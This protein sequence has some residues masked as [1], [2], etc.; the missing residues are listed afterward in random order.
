MF[1]LGKGCG[2]CILLWT[3]TAGELS[4]HVAGLLPLRTTGMSNPHPFASSL[5]AAEYALVVAE[6]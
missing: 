1:N 5:L 6:G 2:P 4:L 3:L